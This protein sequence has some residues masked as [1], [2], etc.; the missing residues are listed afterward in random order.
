MAQMHLMLENQVH[1][2]A[3]TWLGLLLGPLARTP[4]YSLPT[5]LVCAHIVQNCRT[6]LPSWISAGQAHLLPY[7]NLSP[8]LLYFL[9]INEIL[10]VI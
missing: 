4:P 8:F 9:P 6:L 10:N 7:L 1:L 3:S 2:T 5:T